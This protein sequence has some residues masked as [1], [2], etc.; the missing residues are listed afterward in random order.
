MSYTDQATLSRDAVFRG[1]LEACVTTESRSRTDTQIGQAT[2]KNP[3]V[4]VTA[5]M[6]WVTSQPGFDVPEST[7]TDGMILSAVQAVWADVDAQGL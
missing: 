6:P 3:S 5:F 2:L 4:G 1:R 7:I